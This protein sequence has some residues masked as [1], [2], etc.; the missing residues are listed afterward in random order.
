[1]LH[2]TFICT[3][4]WPPMAL[5]SFRYSVQGPVML[6]LTTTASDVDEELL[7]RCLVLTVNETRARE[8][9]QNWRCRTP[10]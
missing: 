7:N 5:S 1:M 4:N 2:H 10:G 6:M 8:R 9:Q 3:K